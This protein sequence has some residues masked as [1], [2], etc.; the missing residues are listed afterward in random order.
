MEIHTPD[1]PITG[2]KDTVK[3]LAMITA[4]V[5]IA[6]A[7]EGMVAWA[8]HKLL[9]R[10]ARANLIAEIQANRKEL[11]DMFAK[12]DGETRGL[13]QADE[14]GA[15]ML[16]HP[17]PRPNMD[18][19]LGSYGADLKNAAVTTGQ[20][21][22]A[23]GYM[24]Y[25]EVRRYA[26]VYDMQAQFLRLQERDSQNFSSIFGF[27]RRI[28]DSPPPADAAIE[29]WRARIDAALADIYVREQLGRQL[30]ARYDDLLR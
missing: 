5:L 7:F 1:H 21:T 19:H 23:F 24:K 8:D 18:I 30:L 22:G 25:A 12:L 6:L 27:V 26:D 17:V 28:A 16:K 3:H 14:V 9:V 13:E 10:E 20:I 15:L 29:E 2:W 4:G 11:T